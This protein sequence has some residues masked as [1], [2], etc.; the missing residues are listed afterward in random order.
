MKR[1]SCLYRSTLRNV[2]AVA[3][4]V[5]FVVAASGCCKPCS[6]CGDRQKCGKKCSK[7]QAGCK[8]KAACKGKCKTPCK[9]ADGKKK[10]GA[11]CKK[12][13]CANKAKTSA[14]AVNTKCPISGRAAN[15]AVT[16]S[17][18]AKTVAFCCGGC[19]G[20]WDKLSSDE[21]S[22]KLASAM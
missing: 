18:G 20:R 6:P 4:S 19:V 5:A 13:C 3:L 15:M 16:A 11:D 14:S 12:P 1:M 21:K 8:D 2:L 22:E 10:C 7:S 9:D 17:Y